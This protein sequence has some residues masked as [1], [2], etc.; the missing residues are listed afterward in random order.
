MDNP[1]SVNR[2]IPPIAVII[3]TRTA[4]VKSQIIIGFEFLDIHDLISGETKNN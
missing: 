2:V 1:D 3:K 4:P